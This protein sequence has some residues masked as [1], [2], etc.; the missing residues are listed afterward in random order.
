MFSKVC[1][2]LKQDVLSH[3]LTDRREL[4]HPKCA[5]ISMRPQIAFQHAYQSARNIAKVYLFIAK[6]REQPCYLFYYSLV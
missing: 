2:T 5:L 6:S 4:F 1:V 3:P